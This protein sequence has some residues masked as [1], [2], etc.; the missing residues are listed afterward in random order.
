MIKRILCGILAMLVIPAAHA[1]ITGDIVRLHVIAQSDSPEDQAFK[2]RVRDAVLAALEPYTEECSDFDEIYRALEAGA[3]DAEAA[4]RQ[5]ALSEGRD[6]P[7]HVETGIFEFD[8]RELEGKVVPAG[9]YRAMRVIIGGGAGHNWWG[10]MYPDATPLKSD[11]DTIYYS[12]VIE[13][14][15]GLLGGN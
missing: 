8:E 4:A 11:G 1:G 2:L 14:L 10:I 5:L 6:V 12:I 3:A 7:I 13:W 9:E 15:M